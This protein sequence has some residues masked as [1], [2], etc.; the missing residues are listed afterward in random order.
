VVPHE[1]L[2]VTGHCFWGSGVLSAMVEHVPAEAAS[3]HDSQA[4]WQARSQQTPWAQKP[5]WHSSADAH[6][7]PR[8]LRPQDPETQKSPGAHCWSEVHEAKQVS[9]LQAYGLH[10]RERE[11]T[12]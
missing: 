11:A 8:G 5:L 12:H 1:L 7:A 6:S 10:V 9:P 3:A 4:D 2:G